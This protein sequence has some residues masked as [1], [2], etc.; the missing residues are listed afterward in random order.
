MN[1][2]LNPP[3]LWLI[4]DPLDQLATNSLHHGAIQAEVVPT[5]K[6]RVTPVTFRERT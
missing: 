2:A 6:G 4:R 1:G 5:L 3:W